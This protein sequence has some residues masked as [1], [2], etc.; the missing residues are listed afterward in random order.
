MGEIMGNAALQNAL[1]QTQK[2]ISLGKI[3]GN[4][5]Q[6]PDCLDTIN[7]SIKISINAFLGEE[8]ELVLLR[9]DL[10]L[11]LEPENVADIIQFA[12][13]LK[14]NGIKNLAALEAAAGTSSSPN[15]T[16]TENVPEKLIPLLDAFKVTT[17]TELN[18]AAK[19]LGFDDAAELEN[20]IEKGNF[21]P[22]EI[23]NIRANLAEMLASGEDVKTLI[24]ASS[25]KTIFSILANTNDL[26]AS[27]IMRIIK[28]NKTFLHEI[29]KNITSPDP[30]KQAAAQR[31]SPKT[32][33]KNQLETISQLYRDGKITKAQ[34]DTLAAWS[35][36]QTLTREQQEI[37]NN[38]PKDIRKQFNAARE[39]DLRTAEAEGNTEY[40]QAAREADAKNRDNAENWGFKD[41]ASEFDANFKLADNAINTIA[42]QRNASERA[43]V[44]GLSNLDPTS[45]ASG[46]INTLLGGGVSDSLSAAQP[47][48][49]ARLQ[50]E[51][52]SLKN[53]DEKI[54]E[55]TE[56][57]HKELAEILRSVSEKIRGALQALENII[58][59]NNAQPEDIPPQFAP[60]AVLESIKKDIAFLENLV[61][62]HSG[63]TDTSPAY[64]QDTSRL[65]S[66]AGLQSMTASSESGPAPSTPSTSSLR[67]A[68]GAQ[69]PGKALPADAQTKQREF[70]ASIRQTIEQNVSFSENIAETSSNAALA[71]ETILP[72]SFYSGIPLALKKDLAVFLPYLRKEAQRIAAEK[73]DENVQEQNRQEN[74]EQETHDE[75]VR[76]MTPFA[77]M[78]M[79]G[80]ITL[81]DYQTGKKAKPDSA[82][83]TAREAA[84][85]TNFALL[86][87]NALYPD[88]PI[89]EQDI[90]RDAFT[91]ALQKLPAQDL[92]KAANQYRSL[93]SFQQQALLR[94][95]ENR[96]TDIDTADLKRLAAQIP[97]LNNAVQG[98]LAK[99]G[100]L[101]PTNI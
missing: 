97:E 38:T 98:E 68:Q 84:R 46:N 67:Q 87:L 50:G 36:N 96:L 25:V 78:V 44:A 59:D 48:L 33:A 32:P 54:L 40:L 29:G 72:D 55:L 91:A 63:S 86:D 53:L 64:P 21:T 70:I 85:K 3:S 1:L 45:S 14:E 12:N 5:I 30:V 83:E 16:S 57:G 61:D 79:Q 8:H 41:L 60:E 89:A 24:Q 2:H 22:K 92:L 73:Y 69:Q 93:P 52:D 20:A 47:D 88:L 80:I 99:R 7:D 4:T 39:Q 27:E 94:V 58:A 43:A 34:A 18:A 11:E 76:L 100:E 9:D 51:V 17:L 75:A 15:T 19:N 95:L 81:D 31:M 42:A 62:Q 74:L 35:A 10:E 23:E 66:L 26:E 49:A 37:L 65:R 101:T 28:E 82:R 13:Q 71:A 90:L 77:R 6:K 56:Q